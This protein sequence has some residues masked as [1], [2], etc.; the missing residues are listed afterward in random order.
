MTSPKL[1]GSDFIAFGKDVANNV[2]EVVEKSASVKRVVYVSSQGAR[3]AEGVGKVRTNYNCERIL[4][5][6]ACDVIFVRNC[7][8]MENWSSAIETIKSENP[9]FYSTIAPL[10]YSLPTVS[11]RDI[12]KTCATV[13][14]RA[15]IT[16]ERS[17]YILCLHGPRNFSVRDVHEAFEKV[18]GKKIQVRLI[19]KEGLRQFFEHSLL[20]ANLVDDFVEM[21][22][23]FLPGSLLEE[24]MN[25][26]SNAV[27]GEDTLV[28]AFSRMWSASKSI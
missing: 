26:L 23:I 16:L 5:S 19:E 25:D 13:A 14:L 17:P 1:D 4:E 20:P 10:D 15:R 18:P 7:F 28:G 11:T 27:R 3:Y 6:L 21:T 22:Q 12:G 24:E 9:Y 2:R 8:F